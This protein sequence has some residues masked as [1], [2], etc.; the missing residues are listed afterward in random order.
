MSKIVLEMMKT[1]VEKMPDVK[2]AVELLQAA[3]DERLEMSWV[4][5]NLALLKNF[6]ILMAAPV[7]DLLIFAIRIAI[8]L[9]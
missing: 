1:L 6:A 5:N 4:I 3:R 9:K 7:P 8:Y 2:E